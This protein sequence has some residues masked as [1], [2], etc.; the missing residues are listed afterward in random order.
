MGFVLASNMGKVLLEPMRDILLSSHTAAV[1]IFVNFVSECSKW[2]KRL[3]D[4]LVDA[5]LSV[6]V[7][8]I[9]GEMDKNEK[10]GFIQLFTG[11]L[12][13]ANYDC[14]ALVGTA[15]VNTGINNKHLQLVNRFGI[16]RCV[17]TSLQERGRNARVA[18]MIGAY[19]ILTNWKMFI[20]LALYILEPDKNPTEQPTEYVGV[21][22]AI[23]PRKTTTPRPPTNTMQIPLTREEK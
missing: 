2:A 18:G 11:H 12:V 4:L 9:H 8:T 3:E 15:A 21:N 22:S 10:F 6:A 16:P 19:V 14:R 23:S 13:M 20:T 1:C 5:F 17:P 7:I